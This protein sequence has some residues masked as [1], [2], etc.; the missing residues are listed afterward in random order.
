[1]RELSTDAILARLVKVLGAKNDAELARLL[2]TNS[3]TISTWKKRDSVP[4][5]IC[6]LIARQQGVSMDWL[7]YGEGP[8]RRDGG[9]AGLQGG[10]AGAEGDPREHAMLALWRELDE[11]AQREIQRAAQEKKRLSA[12]EDQLQELAA[13]VAA[14]SRSA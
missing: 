1:M 7:L 9:E 6:E 3:S 8:M 13:A 2:D 4:L 10:A 14:L 12:I 5:A 11:D